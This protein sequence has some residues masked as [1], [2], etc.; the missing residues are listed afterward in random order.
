MSATHPRLQAL[1]ARAT[2]QAGTS[3][4]ALGLVYPC[5][6]LALDAAQRMA[7]S[8]MAR[9]VLI[10]PRAL[11]AAAAD[12]A[13]VDLRDF[14]LIDRGSSAP[15]AVFQKQILRPAVSSATDR[16]HQIGLVLYNIFK[17]FETT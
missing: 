14:E 15:D 7:H 13:Q 3:P 6:A 9:P 8:G 16:S 5:D 11:I 10:G 4:G 2:A 1:M 12:A 17:H